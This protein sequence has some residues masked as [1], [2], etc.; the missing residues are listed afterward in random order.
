MPKASRPVPQPTPETQH[1][2]DGTKRSEL[3]LQRCDECAHV[4]FPPRPF[5]P[6]CSS[7]EVTVFAARGKGKLLSYVI[8]ERGHPAWDGPYSIAIVEL[9]EGVRMMSNVVEC[10]QTPQALV[11]DMPLEVTFLPLTEEITLPLFRPA[12]VAS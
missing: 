4:Y 3:R 2:W 5:C 1:F 10:P 8:N 6:A 9:D 7:R 11:L 12:G